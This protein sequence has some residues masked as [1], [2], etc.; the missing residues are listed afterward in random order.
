[1]TARLNIWHLLFIFA[2]AALPFAATFSIPSP[3]ERHYTDGAMGMLHDHDWL[4]PKTPEGQPR[5]NKP[6]L[7]YWATAA[8]FIAALGVNPLAARLPFLL[9]AC[10]AVLL[11]WRLARR[12]TGNENT[13]L[14]AAL[15]LLTHG[16]FLLAAI[17]SIPDAWLCLFILLSAEGFL[18]LIVFGETAAAAYWLAYGGAA[19][20][21]MDKGLLGLGIVLFAWVFAWAGK[22]DFGAVKKLLHWPSILV[23]VVFVV[24]W[25]ILAFKLCG[26]SPL[27]V[28]YADQ[29][30]DNVRGHWWSPLWRLPI[31]AAILAVNYL[32]WSLPALE[33]WARGKWKPSAGGMNPR[34]RNFLL[35][36][37]LTLVGVFAFGENISVRYL[38]PAAP[39]GAILVAEILAEADEPGVVLLHA[40][41]PPFLDWS[42]PDSL[43]G[44]A[45]HQRAVGHVRRGVPGGE[46][47]RR[48][49]NRAG[50]WRLEARVALARRERGAGAPPGLSADFPGGEPRAVARPVRADGRPHSASRPAR[51]TR[52]VRGP[53]RDGQRRAA[54][55]WRQ[56]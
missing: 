43:R 31:Y 14:L 18:R 16:Q 26:G 38:L 37:C 48:G 46:F 52:A 1:M 12:L 24:G 27:R 21:T 25:F 39:M 33:A 49:S 50:I 3:D 8:G 44:G 6:P 7:A 5:L 13:A 23:G 20:A 36:W 11:T 29:V 34:A 9:A 17:R 19:L 56:I 15:I 40:A 42:G 45:G 30:T 28:L 4:V 51:Q 53:A 2:L 22:R 32:P 10:A 54:V 35:A 55:S 47:V 41:H